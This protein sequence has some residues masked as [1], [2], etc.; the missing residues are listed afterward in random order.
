MKDIGRSSVI[1]G[2]GGRVGSRDLGGGQTLITVNTGNLLGS[3]QE[4]QNAVA[5]ALK[6]AQRRGIEVAL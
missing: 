2:H 5:S 6:E 1:S 3:T 4:V